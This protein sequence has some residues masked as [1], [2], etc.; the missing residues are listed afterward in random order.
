VS[1]RRPVRSEHGSRPL[2]R[3]VL[4]CVTLAARRAAVS[5]ASLA[6]GEDGR[7][8]ER[9]DVEGECM[10]VR[11]CLGEAGYPV[12][13]A[14]RRLAGGPKCALISYLE[15]VVTSAALVTWSPTKFLTVSQM[16]PAS[17]RQAGVTNNQPL[18]GIVTDRFTAVLLWGLIRLSLKTLKTLEIF[19]YQLIT[20][21]LLNFQLSI[22]HFQLRTKK[23]RGGSLGAFSCAC[24]GVSF[25]GSA[26]LG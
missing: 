21:K 14:C 6:E 23:P 25:G 1:G 10:M 16:P 19:S 18:R 11:R 13:P 5:W 3:P 20:H 2:P 17:L 4:A 9:G 7:G 22:F 8:E 15:E 12:T 26:S 24:A